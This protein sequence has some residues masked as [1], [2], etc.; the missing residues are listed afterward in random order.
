MYAIHPSTVHFP[1]A[2]LLVSGL[3]TLIYLRRGERAWETSAY[4]CLIIGWLAGV[5]A[6]ASGTIDALRQL[7][8][9]DVPRDNALIGW[10]NAHAFL[11]VA[12]VVIYGQA[13]LLRRR[14]PGILDD[15]EARRGYLQRH[16]LGAL[17]LVVGGWIGGHLVYTLGLGR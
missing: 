10:V 1:L 7:V 4:H 8:G 6:L 9:P 14:R 5:V 15:A 3:F 11:N 12:V 16:A 2:L 17:L 13:L